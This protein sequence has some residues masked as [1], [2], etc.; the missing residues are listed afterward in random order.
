MRGGGFWSSL[1]GGLALPLMSFATGP[2]LAYAL[3]PEGRGVIAAASAVMAIVPLVANAGLSMAVQQFAARGMLRT[4]QLTKVYIAMAV[5]G[6]IGAGVVFWIASLA[7]EEYRQVFVTVALA[8]PLIMVL[9]AMRAVVSGY[10]Q[11][12]YLMLESWAIAAGRMTGLIV[13]ALGGWLTP[14]SALLATIIPSILSTVIW[15]RPLFHRRNP[16]VVVSEGGTTTRGPFLRFAAMTWAGQIAVMSNGRVDQAAMAFLTTS[17]QIGYYAVAVSW[18]A[19]PSVL[20]GAAARVIVVR[21]GS[22]WTAE[23]SAAVVRVSLWGGAT[24]VILAAAASP[25]AVPILFGPDFAPTIAAV[26]WLLPGTIAAYANQLYG[27]VLLGYHKP[28]SQTVADGTALVVTAAGLVVLA[29]WLGANGAAITSSIAYLTAAV[30]CYAWVRRLG[31]GNLVIP[32]PGDLTLGK[33]FLLRPFRRH[34]DVEAS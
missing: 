34:T 19:V 23:H 21:A 12:R 29:P 16:L 27:A 20:V 25:I 26:W 5:M 30:I 10:G 8:T 13:L 22:G 9:D 17:E 24:V 28:L 33:E 2:I 11:F 14:V 18:L 6:L 1:I 3:G 31:I 7:P 15:L 32:Q 4:R